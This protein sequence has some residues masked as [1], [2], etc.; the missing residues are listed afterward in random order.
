MVMYTP[1]F[2]TIALYDMCIW[3]FP[4]G[5]AL[6]N[7]PAMQE[8]QVQSLG[9]KDSSEKEQTSQ[10]SILARKSHGQRTLAYYSLWGPKS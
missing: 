4:S 9:R 7:L 3:Y 2:I 6:K 1:I 8:T 10:S 5:S